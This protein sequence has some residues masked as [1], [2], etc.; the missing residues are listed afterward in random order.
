MLGPRCSAGAGVI[1]AGRGAHATGV[2]WRKASDS[3]VWSGR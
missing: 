1:D 3:E 2:A